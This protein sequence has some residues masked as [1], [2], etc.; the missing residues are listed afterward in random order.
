MPLNSPVDF[1]EE[2]HMV[3]ALTTPRWILRKLLDR[4]LDWLRVPVKM[5]T[6]RVEEL[7]Q[8]GCLV[9]R[10]IQY[11]SGYTGAPGAVSMGGLKV[12]LRKK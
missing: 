2:L 9:I 7:C 12:L 11:L 6:Q 4:L 5:I 1:E 8:Q 3:F 10:E